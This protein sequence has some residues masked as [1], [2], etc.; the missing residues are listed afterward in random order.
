MPEEIDPTLLVSPKEPAVADGVRSPY[1]APPVPKTLLRARSIRV[2]NADLEA[3]AKKDPWIKSQEKRIA[4]LKA[5][6]AMTREQKEAAWQKVVKAYW[7]WAHTH[8]KN[9]IDQ[10]EIRE[11]MGQVRVRKL[12][13]RAEVAWQRIHQIRKKLGLKYRTLPTDKSESP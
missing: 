13:M 7:I 4:D 1:K 10:E 9:E 5:M 3:Y 2:T 12:K 8:S 6:P 11:I